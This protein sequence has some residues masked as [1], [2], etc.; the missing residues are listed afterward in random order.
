MEEYLRIETDENTD[1]LVQVFN[2]M[3]VELVVDEQQ[4]TVRRE[5]EAMERG[6]IEQKEEAE[7]KRD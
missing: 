3:V 2:K 1:T 7:E 6:P 5:E 4:E